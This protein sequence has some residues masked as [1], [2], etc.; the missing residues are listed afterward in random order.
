MTEK[1]RLLWN[2]FLESGRAEDYIK[3]FEE[4]DSKKGESA[5]FSS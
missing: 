1:E 5:D 3:Y 4:K 2:T